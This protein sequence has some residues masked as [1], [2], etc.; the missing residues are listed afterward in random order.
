MLGQVFT[1]YSVI[2]DDHAFLSLPIDFFRVFAD[3]GDPNAVPGLQVFCTLALLCNGLQEEQLEFLFQLFCWGQCEMGEVRCGGVGTV[4]ATC[5]ALSV[6]AGT[7][8][9]AGCQ[10]VLPASSQ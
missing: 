3:P 9:Y 8:A 1:D 5:L 7:T 10:C 2:V 6:R 4:P